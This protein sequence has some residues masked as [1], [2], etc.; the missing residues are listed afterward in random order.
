[1]RLVADA[2][3][4]WGFLFSSDGGQGTETNLNGLAGKGES[5][6][7]QTFGKLRANFCSTPRKTVL[8]LLPRQRAEGVDY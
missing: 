8:A 2:G 5:T 4:R 6:A 3:S 7:A 1:M